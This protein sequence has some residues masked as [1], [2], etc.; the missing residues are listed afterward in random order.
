[1]GECDDVALA[2]PGFEGL[3]DVVIHAIDHGARLGE[4]HDLIG[5]LDLTSEHHGLLAV[6]DGQA[7]CLEGQE[8][9]CLGHVDTEG[10]VRHSGIAEEAGD[11]LGS[12]GVEPGLGPDR[13]LESG[14]ATDRVLLVVHVRQLQA[15]GLGRRTEVPQLEVVAGH[16]HPAF[17]LVEGPVADRGRGR[18]PDVRCLEEQKGTEPVRLELL[19]YA[20]D[21]MLAEPLEVHPD[22]PIDPHDSG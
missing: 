3:E 20:G 12:S 14:V 7:L 10:L 16:D 17:A 19:A 11:L 2:N 18:V 5:A 13:P 1:M 9:R 6:D 21:P 22:L 15:V 4:Q 8:H